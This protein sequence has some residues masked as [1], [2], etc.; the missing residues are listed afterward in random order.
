MGREGGRDIIPLQQ[1]HSSSIEDHLVSLCAC[2]LPQSF[3]YLPLQSCT[4]GYSHCSKA[5]LIIVLSLWLAIPDGVLLTGISA[6]ME[7]LGL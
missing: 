2:V 4:P 3:L 5:P 1:G 7:Q 6:E